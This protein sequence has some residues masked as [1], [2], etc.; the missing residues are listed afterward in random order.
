MLPRSRS[1]RLA[2]T[3]ITGCWFS[4]QISFGLRT[5]SIWAIC[6]R[7]TKRGAAAAAGAWPASAAGSAIG[8]SA[9]ARAIETHPVRI[10]DADVDHAVLLGQRGRHLAVEGRRQLVLDVLLGQA[11]AGQAPRGADGPPG[12]DCPVATWVLTS[13]APASSTIL[14]TSVGQPAEHGRVGAEDLDLD[15]AA[16]PAE[17]VDLVFDQRVDF[18]LRLGDLL[19]QLLFEVRRKISSPGRRRAAGF[20]LTRMSPRK[21]SVAYSPFSAPVLRM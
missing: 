15:R 7:S 8:I 5:S 19:C 9:R 20:R 4:R 14:P 3:V 17:V 2:V 11:G 16:H 6:P 13:L 10:A 18:R 1:P 21:V 12:R